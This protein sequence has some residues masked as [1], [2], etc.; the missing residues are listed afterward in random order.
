MTDYVDS[1]LERSST[2]TTSY[3][4]NMQLNT[5]LDIAERKLVHIYLLCELPV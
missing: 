5:T 1:V 4:A 3:R 2:S